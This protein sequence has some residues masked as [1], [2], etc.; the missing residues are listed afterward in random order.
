MARTYKRDSRGRFSGGGGSSA[1]RGL[2]AKAGTSATSPRLKRNPASGTAKPSGTV[3][4]TRYGRSVDQFSREMQAMSGRKIGAKVKQRPATPKEQARQAGIKPRGTRTT[5]PRAFRD[6]KFTTSAPTGTIPRRNPGAAIPA[7]MKQRRT[8]TA[9][10]ASRPAR[11]SKAAAAK[12]AAAG[13]RMMRGSFAKLRR[14][15]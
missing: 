14:K 5:A 15:R 8:L 7:S 6:T 1:R 11:R 12:A 3:S 10:A 4:G 13:G 2:R 9:E